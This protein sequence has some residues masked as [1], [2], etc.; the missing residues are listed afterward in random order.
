MGN[1]QGNGGN[2]EHFGTMQPIHYFANSFNQTTERKLNYN[3]IRFEKKPP[4]GITAP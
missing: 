2:G 4:D 1:K 3:P